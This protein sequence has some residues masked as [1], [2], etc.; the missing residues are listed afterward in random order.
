[1]QKHGTD[2]AHG[3]KRMRQLHDDPYKNLE[4]GSLLQLV[5]G[6]EYLKEETIRTVGTLL[7]VMLDPLR[8]ILAKSRPE[9]EAEL[10]TLAGALLRSP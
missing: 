10:N 4:N 1:M 6:R 2:V 9:R 8:E 5:S 3:L 7:R